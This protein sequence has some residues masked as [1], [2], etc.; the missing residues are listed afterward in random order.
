MKYLIY[1]FF[2]VIPLTLLGESY[3]TPLLQISSKLFPKILFMEK[4]TKER[5]QSSINLAIVTSP[6]NQETARHFSS[7][8]QN[9]YPDGIND[10][11]IH[12][13]IVSAKE[14]LTM[15]NIHGIILM[16]PPDNTLLEALIQNS[17]ENKIVTF[18]FD[19]TLLKNGALISLYIRK[20]VK[21]YLN[22]SAL[23]QA[24]FTFEYSFIKLSEP[25]E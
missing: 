19:P 2:L 25:Y 14:A 4:G 18:C 15:K 1:F 10:H 24:S 12:L 20:N 22:I 21:P 16:I 17:Y 13:S 6:A 7:M 9:H 11:P 5:I 8:V 23:K 3:D